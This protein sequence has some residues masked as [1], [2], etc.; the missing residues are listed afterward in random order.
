VRFSHIQDIKEKLAYVALDFDVENERASTEERV[1]EL[2]DGQLVTLCGAERYNCGEGSFRPYL[3]GLESYG[4]HEV[5][6][7]TIMRS[8]VE[9]RRDFYRNIILAGGSTCFPGFRNR[10]EKE[11]IAL[12]PPSMKVNV[13]APPNRHLS[14]WLGGSMQ[15]SRDAF[16]NQWVLREEFE[17][18][19]P[20]IVHKRC[21]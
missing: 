7:N 9:I 13:I 15:A 6:N 3:L 17:E 19:G 16:Q 12:A 11:I 5:I 8:S 2:L 18:F 20:S 14:A 21:Y 4:I 10:L 1:Y